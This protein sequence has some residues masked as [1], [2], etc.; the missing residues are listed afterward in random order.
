M[1]RGR[2]W[3]K[4]RGTVVEYNLLRNVGRMALDIGEWIDVDG[5]VGMRVYRDARR[6]WRNGARA[7]WCGTAAEDIGVIMEQRQRIDNHLGS[8]FNTVVVVHYVGI[9]VIKRAVR[10]VQ[11]GYSWMW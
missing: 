3:G 7:R 11:V 6:R 2:R 8:V 4:S 1:T 5:V 10:C 9:Y